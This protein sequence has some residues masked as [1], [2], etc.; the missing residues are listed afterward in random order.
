MTWQLANMST[1]ERQRFEAS[2]QTQALVG[3]AQDDEGG[4]V[5]TAAATSEAA[6]AAA[7]V[8]PAQDMSR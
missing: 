2:G 6:A 7:T 4:G 8:L 3:S 1:E 5:Y